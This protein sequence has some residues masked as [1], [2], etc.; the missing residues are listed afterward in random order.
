MLYAYYYIFKTLWR[1]NHLPGSQ[2]TAAKATSAAVQMA[3][4]ATS[5][6]L[7]KN[8][9]TY[10]ANQLK[11]PFRNGNTQPDG[12]AIHCN[13]ASGAPQLNK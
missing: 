3:S 13:G 12:E 5:G 7:P 8:V 10:N 4:V 11:S 6:V 1:Q 9:A 2:E